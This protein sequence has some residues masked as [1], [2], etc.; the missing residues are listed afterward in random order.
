MCIHAKI[1]P[2]LYPI[3]KLLPISSNVST[4]YA[5]FNPNFSFREI[6]ADQGMIEFEVFKI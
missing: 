4:I 1:Q 6:I 3:V 5:E 2:I